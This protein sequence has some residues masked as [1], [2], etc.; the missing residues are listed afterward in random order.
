MRQV[1]P[2]STFHGRAV[3]ASNLPHQ[4]VDSMLAMRPERA[5]H[6]AQT[7]H[8]QD[9]HYERIEETGR[10]EIDVHVRDNAC[11]NEKRTGDCKQPS[12]QA[13][14]A[15]EKYSHSDQHRQKR[16]PESVAAVETP[17]RAD[18]AYLIA[19]QISPNASHGETDKKVEE[20]AGRSAYVA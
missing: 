8:K 17:V 13:A 2:Q 12:D 5:C 14:P 16:D 20:P 18:H 1:S 6:E 9:Q 15:P 3:V 4:L 19:E 11:E 7:A 10:P